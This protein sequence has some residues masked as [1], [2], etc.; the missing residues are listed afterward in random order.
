MIDLI[1]LITNLKTELK[2]VKKQSS[3]EYLEIF[4]IFSNKFLFLFYNANRG[5]IPIVWHVDGAT[6]KIK[7]NKRMSVQVTIGWGRWWCNKI[8]KIMSEK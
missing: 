6:C 7:T 1:K 4:I 3:Y 5:N 8:N 2:S